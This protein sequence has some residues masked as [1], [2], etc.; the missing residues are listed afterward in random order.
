MKQGKV[1]TLL[2][3]AAIVFVGRGGLCI[4]MVRGGQQCCLLVWID[5]VQLS[6]GIS[7]GRSFGKV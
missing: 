7:L 2:V 6:L 5:Y 4:G 3:G 1:L